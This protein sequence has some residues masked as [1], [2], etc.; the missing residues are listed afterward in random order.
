MTATSGG[1]RRRSKMEKINQA[2]EEGRLGYALGKPNDG[3]G[4]P[5][6]EA[7]SDW[8]TGWEDACAEEE[9][10]DALDNC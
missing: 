8:Q 1:N 10:E 4:L 7:R 3:N 5:Q 2:Y 9:M 6:G